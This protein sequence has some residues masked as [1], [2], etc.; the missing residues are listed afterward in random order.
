[1]AINRVLLLVHP[2]YRPDRRGPVGSTTERDV[3][4]ALKRMGMKCSVSATQYDLAELDRDLAREKPQVVFNLLEEFRDEGLFDFHPVAYLESKGI[5]YT[6]CNPR[7]LILTRNKFW[8]AMM[9]KGLGTKVPESSLCQSV[10]PSPGIGFPCILKL[11]NEH[12]SLGMSKGNVV[13]SAGQF[14]RRLIRMKQKYRSQVMVQEFIPGREITVSV[15]GNRD[16]RAFQPWELHLQSRQAIAT[17]RIKFDPRFRRKNGITARRFRCRD[18]GLIGR[19]QKDAIKV[20]RGLGLNGY[21]RFDFRLTDSNEYFL[22]DVNPNPNLAC[23]EDFARSAAHEGIS[24][25]DLLAQI[26]RLA[27]S[28]KPEI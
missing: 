16:A 19:M 18:A 2:Y 28:Y 15:F 1:M 9:A 6:G 4:R 10:K 24:Y 21:A 26:M 20:F 23:D 7:G 3:F 14:T 5:P 25:E 17:E 27:V 8:T 13:R 12:A 22:I 11:N